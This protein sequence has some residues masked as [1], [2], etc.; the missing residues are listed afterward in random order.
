MHVI[1]ING[2][3]NIRAGGPSGYLYYLKEGLNNNLDLNDNFI[4]LSSTETHSM[5]NKVKKIIKGNL[6]PALL[7]KLYYFKDIISF[8]DLKKNLEN[9][10]ENY[11]LNKYDFN[12][13]KENI[14]DIKC[15]HSHFTEDFIRVNNSL[16][17]L[18]NGNRVI[19]ILTSHSPEACF[20]QYYRA[21]VLKFGET[22]A[23]KLIKYRKEIDKSAF[24]NADVIIFPS[25]EALEP[26]Y[27]TWDIFADVIKNKDIRYVL[28]GCKPLQVKIDRE[29]YRSDLGITNNDFVI[30]F[31]GRHETVKGYDKL[32]VFAEKIWKYDEK[33][34]F[35]VGGKLEGIK[36]LDDKRWIEVGWTND[37][38]SLINA[39]DLF[40]LPNKRTFFDLVLLE[41]MSIGIPVVASF[42]GGNK[43]VARIS[44]GVK[45]YKDID[46]CVQIVIDLMKNRRRLK[47]MGFLN[48]E[49]Y[50]K[51]FTIR[52]FSINYLE[53][54]HNICGE[55]NLN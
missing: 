34:K 4:F 7:S 44:D 51:N 13:I 25:K 22:K 42:T 37:P 48:K 17:Q 23:N 53:T 14:R 21:D 6:S 46:E 55:Y 28:T 29:K 54:I 10:R 9:W 35:M 32:K 3:L 50:E 15:I 31:V 47:E 41:V 30:S 19:K 39:S 2:S 16:N 26:Y 18:N 11:I 33:I 27:E 5:T 52:Q 24:E 43:T 12:F 8:P 20:Q 40:I 45:L 1:Y 49:C 36:P 38:G